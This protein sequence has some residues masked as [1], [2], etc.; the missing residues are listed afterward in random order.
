[1]KISTTFRKL[2][3]H[4]GVKLWAALVWLIIW[5]LLYEL[6]NEDRRDLLLS[7][8]IQVASELWRMWGTGDYWQ[9]VLFSSLDVM[10]GMLM[11]AFLGTL[12]GSIAYFA[13]FVR[14]LFKPLISVIR[15]IPVVTFTI[16]AIYWV[17]YRELGMFVAF[18]ICFP[19]FYSHSLSGLGM[20]DEKLLEM[21][22]MFKLSF[23]RKF[24][25]IY[26]PPLITQLFA[27]GEVAVGLAWKSG[28]AA[29]YIAMV[30]NILSIGAGLYAS[31]GR[32]STAE[33]LAWT[34]TIVA[35]SAL[36]SALFR[37]LLRFFSRK[38]GSAK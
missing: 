15:S 30:T 17:G 24:K 5:Q 16:M 11:G 2:L 22:C 18:L 1:M 31:K 37:A 7:S 38:W 28:I 10:S 8:P 3:R 9:R 25:S 20:A 32:W 36:F 33:T 27:A 23:F 14:E 19:V 34:V 21:A 29:E 13:S 35:L 12:L 6:T 4:P 26:L